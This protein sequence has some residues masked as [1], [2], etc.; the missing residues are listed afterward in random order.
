MPLH[1]NL[2]KA[3]WTLLRRLTDIIKQHFAKVCYLSEHNKTTHHT[4]PPPTPQFN[5]GVKAQRFVRS[6]LHQHWIWGEG[7]RFRVLCWKWIRKAFWRH[8]CKVLLNYARQPYAWFFLCLGRCVYYLPIQLPTKLIA[9]FAFLKPFF[10]GTK[11][12][13]GLRST[14]FLLVFLFFWKQ[15]INYITSKQLIRYNIVLV[16][17]RSCVICKKVASQSGTKRKMKSHPPPQRR[18]E[19]PFF[20]PGATSVFALCPD[21]A[22]PWRDFFA[23]DATSA[24]H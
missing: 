7:G 11:N 3:L 2:A 18:R 8:H 16:T 23:N 24:S 13:C 17:C 6:S 15:T 5:V 9:F 19:A 10:A 4:P 12:A 22:A 1:L 21:C 20:A 14:R